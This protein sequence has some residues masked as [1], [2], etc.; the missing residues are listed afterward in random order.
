MTRSWTKRRIA[1]L[2]F[3]AIP[4]LASAQAPSPAGRWVGAVELPGQ[5][6]EVF[7]TLAADGGAWSGTIDIPAQR[8]KALPLT[9]IEV[10][11]S[12]V[13]FAIAGIPGDPTFSGIRVSDGRTITGDLTQGGQKFPFRLIRPV[14]GKAAAQALDGFDAFVESALKEWKV[15]G[16]AVAIVKDGEVVLSRGY[17]LRDVKR[18]LPVTPETLFAIGS[19]TK[20]FT[21][22]S[23]GV[24]ADDG[25][26]SW[27]TPVKTYLPT[28]KLEDPFATDRMTPKDLVTHRSG[29][30]RHDLV[31]YNAPL[32]RKEIFDRLQYLEPNVDFRSKFQ[33]QNLMFLTAGY[34]AG[35][36][37]GLEWEEL[38]R[39]RIFHPLGMKSSNFSVEASKATADFALPYNEKDK[40]IQEIAF[41][42]IDVVGPAGSINSNLND[43]VQW[44]RLHLS[45]GKVLETRVISEAGLDEM[46]RPQMVMRDSGQDPE[47][48]L[49]SYGLGWFIESYRGKR[50]VH[51]GGNI[52]GFS[53]M[54]TFLPD[55]D[56][57]VVAL[58]NRDGTPLPEILC[59]VAI[60]RVLGLEPIDWN[61]R[62]KARADEGEKAADRAKGTLE[63]FERRKGTRPS[64]ALEE[65]AGDY[66]HPA[67]GTLTVA[68]EGAAN[69]KATIHAI[70]MKLDHWHYDTFRANPEDPALAEEKIFVLFR[71]NTKG[72]VDSLTMPLEAQA[73]EI[74]FTKKPP[75][76]LSDPKFLTTLAGDYVFVDQPSVAVTIAVTGDVLTAHIAGQPPYTLEPYRGAEFK[77]KELTGFAIRFVPDARGVVNEALFIQPEGVYKARRKP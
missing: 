22:M 63:V 43:M 47:I 44:V 5:K 74:V 33:Y 18:N 7:V 71:T 56:V 50:R 8:A 4:G 68:R 37:S 25:R 2:L 28:F 60:D 61:A 15:P 12:A 57:G 75:A 13:T 53:A 72:D 26:I 45:D 32:T 42:N 20:A 66:E 36:V 9:A 69:L 34:L 6:L 11:G 70:P 51:H 73:S 23:L 77:F 52:D 41:R 40:A 76:R 1:A 16:V 10:E 65:Y 46:H 48:V 17:G 38:V 21:V 39:R 24:L 27:D 19:A 49:G 67:Y 29:L 30:P 54:V 59:R 62:I 64:H 3:L 55:Q 14:P 31:W 35:E 58:A